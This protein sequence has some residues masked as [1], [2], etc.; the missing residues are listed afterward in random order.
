MHWIPTDEGWFLRWCVCVYVCGGGGV[1]CVRELRLTNIKLWWS[2]PVR[3]SVSVF[4]FPLLLP[5]LLLLLL[6]KS[7]EEEKKPRNQVNDVVNMRSTICRQGDSPSASKKQV[8]I[9]W[10][11]FDRCSDCGSGAMQPSEPRHLS[12]EMNPRSKSCTFVVGLSG[13]KKFWSGGDRPAV[14]FVKPYPWDNSVCVCT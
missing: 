10:G 6:Y 14:S 11:S 2:S 3:V 5:L 7:R 8:I 13:E 4:A 9:V 12:L 1:V